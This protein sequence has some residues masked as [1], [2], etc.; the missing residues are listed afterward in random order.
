MMRIVLT[1]RSGPSLH[2]VNIW[3]LRESF[4]YHNE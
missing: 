2:D 3:D 1:C 4:L